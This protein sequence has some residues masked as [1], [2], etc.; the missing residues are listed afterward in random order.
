MTDHPEP[1]APFPRRA[2]VILL[3][4]ALVLRIGTNLSR[5]DENYAEGIY[6]GSVANALTLGAPLW[7]RH[8]AEI[9]HVPGS[10]VVAY[11]AA[12]FYLVLGPTTFSLRFAGTLFHLAALAGWMVL[13]H[14]RLGRRVAILGGALFVLAPPG[15]A[16]MAILSYG[17]HVESL[18]FLFFAAIYCLDWVSAR[19]GAKW[20]A[21]FLGGMGVALAVSFHLQAT[22]GIAALAAA[23]AIAVLPRLR[24]GAF[25]REL[26]LGFV[27]GGALGALPGWILFTFTGTSA[28]SLWG[29]SPTEHVKLGG[30]MDAAF[31]K[32]ASLLKDGFSYSFQWESRW[33][34]DATLLLSLGCAL[35]LMIA[36]VRHLLLRERRLVDLAASAGFFV[37]YPIVFSLVF[38][39]SSSNFQIVAATSNALEVRYVLPVLPFLLLPIAVAAAKLCGGM[40]GGLVDLHDKYFVRRSRP[41]A[42]LV[43]GPP[44]LL[45]AIGSLSTWHI[46]TILHEPAR[47]GY[48]WEEFD[49]HLLWGTLPAEDQ[50]KLAHRARGVARGGPLDEELE[51]YVVSHANILQMLDSVKR[52]DSSEE[53]TWVLRY[54]PPRIPVGHPPAAG[55]AVIRWVREAPRRLRPFR[56][57]AAGEAACRIEPFHPQGVGQLLLSGEAPEDRR[58]LAWGF[59]R[60]LMVLAQDGMPPVPRFFDGNKAAARV[61]ALPA[62]VSRAD[63]SF[64]LGFRLGLLVNE[65]FLPGDEI[66]HRILA[67]FPK[68]ALPGF[69][70]GL[71]AGYRMRFLVP[72]T[73]ATQTPAAD[74]LLSLLPAELGDAFRAGLHGE[75]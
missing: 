68:D 29:G 26:L 71:G 14:R 27:P 3:L 21:P 13:L 69:A 64:G 1:R 62:G 74:R 72:P 54:A 58:A 42:L 10:I 11:L 65:F 9:P 36:T 19:G 6:R 61:A 20:R 24:E 50:Q 31:Q 25:W 15:F 66:L 52:Y 37:L 47:R 44:L 59:G 56:G 22:L 41:L 12:P 28:L 53:W 39:A 33:L 23:C 38:A 46:P 32:L 17:D 18:P 49:S 57:V 7:P 5:I 30:Q 51:G 45:G 60:G 16:K 8:M 35:G 55:D 43:A 75:R 70:R 40:H 73:A 67:A 34:A 63:V 4:V 48:F 2:L